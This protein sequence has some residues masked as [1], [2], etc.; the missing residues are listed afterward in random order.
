M[1]CVRALARRI[2][3][4]SKPAKDCEVAAKPGRH[5]KG[6]VTS[7]VRHAVVASWKARGIGRPGASA[8]QIAAAEQ[9]LGVRLPHA[10]LLALS[11]G[12]DG[13]DD[14]LFTFL[15][16]EGLELDS[17]HLVFCEFSIWCHWYGLFASAPGEVFMLHG[18]IPIRLGVDL[19]AFLVTYLEEPLDLV[20]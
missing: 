10:D 6:S 12:T 5:D 17:G 9:R 18:G 15:D 19:D 20:R 13:M 3:V 2:G 1:L 14:N 8:T 16:T 7:S 4:A 11:N